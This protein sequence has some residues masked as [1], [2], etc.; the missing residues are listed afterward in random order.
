MDEEKSDSV[1]IEFEKEADEAYKNVIQ[2]KAETVDDFDDDEFGEAFQSSYVIKKNKVDSRKEN[3]AENKESGKV[4]PW[5]GDATPNFSTNPTNDGGCDNL[6]DGANSARD[7]PTL[8]DFAVDLMTRKT[9]LPQKEDQ[10]SPNHSAKSCNSSE[11]SDRGWSSDHESFRNRPTKTL[12]QVKEEWDHVETVTAGV[13]SGIL[14]SPMVNFT[15]AIFHFKSANLDEYAASIKP[16]MKHRGFSAVW[17]AIAGPPKINPK[18][19]DDRDLIFTLGLCPFDNYDAMHM[20][21]LQTIYKKL[22]ATNL[23]CPRYGA[24]WESI[25]FQGED[26]STDLRGCG[27]LGLLT[28]LNFISN[29]TTTALAIDVY[30]LSE[31]EV[32]NFPFC[33][34]GIN[35]TRITLQIFREGKLNKECN[36]RNQVFEVFNDLYSAI[37][38]SIYRI[39]K[40]QHKNISDSGFVIHEVETLA[41]KNPIPMIRTFQKVMNERKNAKVPTATASE[42]K[43]GSSAGDKIEKFIGVCDLEDKK[44]DAHFV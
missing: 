16:T 30:R 6:I 24:H 39:W 29:P 40:T 44:E 26:P 33:V 5:R 8:P 7:K 3:R 18:L 38:H 10:L 20:L 41:K 11:S 19:K 25:G 27:M 1:D 14:K 32:Q 9:S 17:N 43:Q 31:D 2:N 42:S 22:T 12:N 37:Y 36:S 28:T 23:D 15:E 4:G 34:M 13:E 35:I 21:I